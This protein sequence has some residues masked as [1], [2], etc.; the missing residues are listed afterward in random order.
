MTGGLNS[1]LRTLASLRILELE[2]GAMTGTI[3]DIFGDLPALEKLDLNFNLIGGS[4]PESIFALPNLKQLD[5]N[6]NRLEGSISTKI[7]QLTSLSFFQVHSNR[8]SGAIPAEFGI[9]AL[10]GTS[11]RPNLK[12]SLICL[13]TIVLLPCLSTFTGNA[14]FHRNNFHGSMPQLI[15]AL[16]D[17]EVLTADCFDLP[18]RGS[19]PYVE[20]DCCTQCF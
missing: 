8:M 9:L 13:L 11:F 2:D 10:L 1:E 14:T 5:L 3:P 15:C 17:L 6:N 4:I 19:P 16:S 7:G 12:T 18:S 20:C